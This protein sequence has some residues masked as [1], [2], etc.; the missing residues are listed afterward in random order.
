MPAHPS[1]KEQFIVDRN[2]R[3]VSVV[4]DLRTYERL[5]A[6]EEELADRTS[7]KAAAKRVAREIS[8][9]QFL[10]IGE[11]AAKRRARK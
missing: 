5:R 2:G 7:L 9:G 10:T 4:L 6:A 11:Y 3:R 1:T 8:D